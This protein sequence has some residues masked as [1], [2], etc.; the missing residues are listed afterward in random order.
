LQT[1]E[2]IHQNRSDKNINVSRRERKFRRRKALSDGS[3]E[4]EVPSM[5]LLT[6]TV[7][8]MI[9][10]VIESEDTEPGILKEF[11]FYVMTK[12]VTT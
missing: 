11:A 9:M 7:V 12:K 8:M 6:P 5:H 1:K 4:G 2:R 10:V 3:S